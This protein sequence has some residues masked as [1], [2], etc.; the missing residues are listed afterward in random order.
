MEKIRTFTD[1]VAWQHAHQLALAIYRETK[2]FPRDEVY[3]LSSQMRRA[4][5][6]VSANIAEGFKR[7]HLNDQLHF[8]SFAAASCE[9][10]RAESF[11]A[12]DLLYLEAPAATSL[13]DQIDTV[14]KL[15]YGWQTSRSRQ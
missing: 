2:R 8:Y 7:Q 14:S 1:L 12:R 9:E 4:A 3:G 13:L 5:V 6:S 11:L 15:L 10:L